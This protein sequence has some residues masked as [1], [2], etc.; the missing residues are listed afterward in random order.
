MNESHSSIPFAPD[1]DASASKDDI[2]NA[3]LLD[4]LMASAPIGFAFFD[5][6]LK[7]QR[8]NETL[9]QINGVPAR[10]HI[11]KTVGDVLPN[12][13]PKVLDGLRQVLQTE[14][15]LV[16]LEIV[17]ETSRSPG[18]MRIWINSFYPVY[19]QA[20]ATGENRGPLL[21]VG[22]IVLE[23]TEQR[24]AEKELQTNREQQRVFLR[25]I[26]FNLS[27][28]KLH[29]CESSA[30]FPNPLPLVGDPIALTLP[31]LRQLRK[32]MTR[33]A[34][35]MGLPEERWQDLETA[36]GEAAMNAV[37][38]GGGGVARVHAQNS[39][40]GTG[41]M[42]IW[43]E[44]TGGGIALD[45]LH[46]ATLERGFTTAGSLGH[47]WPMLLKT[48]DRVYLLTGRSGTTVVI[49]QDETPPQPAW[50]LGI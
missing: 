38:H 8:V 5:R 44:D 35:E 13:D 29:L 18:E 49:E 48:S 25:D 45:R 37:V 7:Y 50:L 15:A 3:A 12:P 42:Q 17:G 21:G 26:L 4:T 9:A 10:K 1:A 24:R 27:E 47:G 6:D 46:R 22:A 20:A 33:V 43:V 41:R 2:L 40:N 19:S 23:V 14:E 32:H 34:E 31:T 11:G 30:D 28:G 16:N 36:V 39:Q